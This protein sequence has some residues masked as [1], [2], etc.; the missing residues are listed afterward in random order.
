MWGGGGVYR[1]RGGGCTH[2]IRGPSRT[3]IDRRIIT[4][5]R[6]STSGFTDQADVAC[7]KREVGAGKAFFSRSVAGQMGRWIAGVT[8]LPLSR[9]TGVH[10][11]LAELVGAVAM[12]GVGVLMLLVPLVVVVVVLLLLLRYFFVRTDGWMNDRPWL[13]LVWRRGDRLLLPEVG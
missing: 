5:L 3:I 9:L 6:S 4:L 2:V 11:Q 7:T 12:V 13:T 10:P 8:S 1:A